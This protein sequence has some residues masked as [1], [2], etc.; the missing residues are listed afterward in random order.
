MRDM[1]YEL[2]I[3][4]ASHLKEIGWTRIHLSSDSR[5]PWK[6]AEH[7]RSGCMHRNG[8]PVSVDFEGQDAGLTFRWSFDLETRE[9]NG[10][11][12][13][14]IDTEGCRYVMA[15]LPAAARGQFRTILMETA[16][17]VRAKAAEWQALVDDQRV[18]AQM[19]SD[20][21]GADA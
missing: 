15:Q 8:I 2:A 14:K 7:V 16:K 17:A 20:I 5:P 1:T 21:F 13:F 10:N 9:A 12:G 11:S 3:E 6:L 18:A 19:L 4:K